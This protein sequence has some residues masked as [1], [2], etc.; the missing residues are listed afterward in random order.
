R[1]YDLITSEDGFGVP[2]SNVCLLLDEDATTAR[3]REAFE[4]GLIE[5]AESGDEVLIFFA[6]H[7]AQKKDQNGD[8]PDEWDET[9]LLHD[10]RVGSQRDFVDDELNELL[11]RLHARTPNIVL[12]LDS[13]N[14]GTVTRGDSGLVARFFE[15]DDSDDDSDADTQAGDSGDGN[16]GWGGEALP[17]L[18]AM[19]AASDG[20]PALE[21][22][23]EGI[24]TSAL[25]AVLAEAGGR[26]LTY[27]Q[28]ARQV[29]PLVA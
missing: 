28:V 21:Q 25:L 3:F 29:P 7:G 9:L 23:G 20:T 17:G 4:R 1:V 2:A 15:P 16:T 22:N 13:C 26:P 19:T 6:G 18:I 5:H 8:E 27:A 14:S 10:A 24:F 11:A 12:I